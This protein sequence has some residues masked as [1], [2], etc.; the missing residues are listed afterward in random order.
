M[1][2]F[3]ISGLPSKLHKSFLLNL[4][5]TIVSIVADKMQIPIEW[6]RVFFPTDLLDDPQFPE[7]G[8]QTI[9]ITLETAMLH[10]SQDI[11]IT[12]IGLN[13]VTAIARTVWGQLDGKYEVEVFVQHLDPSLKVKLTRLE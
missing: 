8:C 13:T 2:F 1:P 12:K 11:E 10:N 6:V 5:K 7:E 9:Y 3:K 4:R